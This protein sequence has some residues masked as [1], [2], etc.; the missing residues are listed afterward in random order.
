MHEI[1]EVLAATPRDRALVERTLT[2]GYAHA[3][4]LEAERRRV[5]KELRA[6]AAAVEGGDV[7]RKTKELAALARRVEL[8]EV[9]LAG[10]REQLG[11]LRSEYVESAETPARGR[12]R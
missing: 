12:S 4:S 7:A 5:L 6:L 11:R 1:S 3:L 9:M 10:L 8:Q 2:D